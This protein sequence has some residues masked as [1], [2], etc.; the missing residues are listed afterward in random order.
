MRDDEGEGAPCRGPIDLDSGIVHIRIGPKTARP[1]KMTSRPGPISLGHLQDLPQVRRH[2]LPDQL[3]PALEADSRSSQVTRAGRHVPS[4]N[5]HSVET[6]LVALDVQHRDARIIAVIQRSHVY[7]PERD[8]PCALGLKYREALFTHESGGDP[9][10]KMQPVL[11]GLPFG[12]ALEVQ[13]RTH[14]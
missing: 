12:D 3:R 14:A 6:E 5:R 4:R 1:G 11:G 13:S 7:R 8:Q 10:V 9:H 2:T